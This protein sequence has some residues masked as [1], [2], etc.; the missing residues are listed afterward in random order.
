[1][2]GPGKNILF[3]IDYDGT[4]AREDRPVE[5]AVSSSIAFLKEKYGFKL[6]LATARPLSDIERYTK[7]DLFDA[8]SLELG[9]LIHLPPVEII[10]F[11]PKWW[12]IL[13]KRISKEVPAVN[14]GE[15]LYYFDETHLKNARS[16][17]EAIGSEFAVEIKKVGSRTHVFAPRGLDKGV[18]LSRLLRLTGWSNFYTVAI[19]DS[20]SDLPLFRVANFKI[21]VA[22][23][24]EELKAE[25][26]LVTDNPYGEGVLEGLK[27]ILEKKIG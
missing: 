13:V 23:A 8:L 20:P 17:F 7:V 6:V 11:K 14:V 24:A 2:N 1:M 4:L 10:V 21:A 16:T 27:K 3:V 18:G 26:D 15:V 22:N 25:A 19:G 12:N 9:S 5:E